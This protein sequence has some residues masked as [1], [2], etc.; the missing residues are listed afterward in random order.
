MKLKGKFSG[1][2]SSR[3]QELINVVMSQE[4][5]CTLYIKGTGGAD[6]TSQD[7]YCNCSLSV[8]V[9][10]KFRVLARNVMQKLRDQFTGTFI[11][12]LF[13]SLLTI[14]NYFHFVMLQ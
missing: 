12:M 9:N 1:G 6:Y 14:Y 8:M 7:H 10:E 4:I 13:M 5:F 11:L 3:Q 2:I